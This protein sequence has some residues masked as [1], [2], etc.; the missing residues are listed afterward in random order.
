[1]AF[2]INDI[3][4]TSGNAKLYNSWTSH[5]SKYDTSS[6]YNW[7]Q[8][9]LPLYDI[10]ERTYELWEQAGFPTSSVPGFSL[11]VSADTPVATLNADSTIFTSVS[12]CM[13]A[14]PKIIRFPILIEVAN[15][16][17]LGSL[18]LHNLRIE[19]GGSLEIINRGYAK[20]Y[21]ASST[22]TDTVEPQWNKWTRIVDEVT[23]ADLSGAIFSGI[24]AGACTSAVNIATRVL[25]SVTDTRINAINAFTYPQLSLRKAPLGVSL[26]YTGLFSTTTVNEFRFLPYEQDASFS[27]DATISIADVSATK[28]STGAVLARDAGTTADPMGGS[29]YF[30]TCKKISVKNCDGPI[31]I[32]N[33]CVN[34]ESMAGGGR[35]VGIEITNS[36]VLLEN[37][38]AA[39]CREAGFKFNNSKVVLSRS[40]FSYRNYKLDTASIRSTA[41]G[42]G[43]HAINSDISISALV[44][45]TAA[46]E[47]GAAGEFG[48]SGN[49]VM[50]IA[51]RNSV[52]FK[53]DNSKL[54][55]GFSRMNPVSENT[56]GIISSELNTSCG[57]QLTN[58]EIN[59]EGLIDVYGN[60]QGIEANLSK[61][62]YKNLCVEDHPEEGIVSRNS[63][64][65]LKPMKSPPTEAGETTRKLTDFAKNSQHIVLQKQSSFAFPR[66]AD[67]IPIL[68]GHTS[69]S[70]AHGAVQWSNNAHISLPA[71]SIEDNSNAEFVQ[72]KLVARDAADSFANM[73]TYGLGAKVVK[74]SSVAFYG[75]GSGCSFIWGPPG[76]TL[77]QKVAGLYADDNSEINLHGP[78]VIAQFGVDVLAENNSTITICP[79]RVKD[80]WAYNVSGFNLSSQGNHTSVELHSTRACL[81]ANKNSNINM[82]DL[83]SYISSWPEAGPGGAAIYAAGTDYPISTFGTNDFIGS[84]SLQFY[85]N[86][87][88]ANANAESASVLTTGGSKVVNAIPSFPKFT[89]KIRMNNFL[90][91]DQVISGVPSA[92]RQ[93]ISKGGVCVRAVEDSIVNVTNVHF[94]NGNQGNAL[95]GII[96]TASG[97]TCDRL[98]IWNMADTSRLNAAFCSVSGMYPSDAGYHGPSALWGSA[99]GGTGVPANRHEVI[100][101]GAPVGTPDTGSLSILDSFGAGSAVWVVPSGVTFNQPF[102]RYYPVAKESGIAT[103]DKIYVPAL[104]S[105]AGINVSSTT[106]RMYGASASHNYSNQGVFRIYWSPKSSAKFLQNDASGYDTGTSAIASFSGVVGPAYQ[107]FSQGY[108]MSAPC[109]AM[110]LDTGANVSSIYPGLLKMSVAEDHPTIN[111]QLWTSGFY[112]CDEFVDDNPT[113]CMLDES[114]SDT[115]ANSKNA[116]LGSSGR[117]KKV[118]LYRSRSGSNRGAEA[119]QGD[120][121]Y[122]LGYKS[123]NI[124]DLK[125]DN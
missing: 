43:F 88:N 62:E 82:L 10:E 51:S 47:A 27:V 23:S 11:T 114:A 7:E 49:D 25:S 84:G 112:Y 54:I 99:A 120:F 109:S 102:E 53:L 21:N 76:Y 108:N 101:S 28:Q 96:Y 107:V 113:Q 78:T 26:G 95:D 37:C 4:T 94:P 74:N 93:N 65:I 58:S 125:R 31:Y 69:F 117:P 52:G 70:G 124:F 40:A 77:Q 32:R 116:T 6:F 14:L 17:D 38:S 8:D 50:V 104:L 57:I 111:S 115:F 121:Y 13:A 87:N 97:N 22:C 119:H 89:E 1:M 80:S 73:P 71:I 18:E 110:L 81:V 91:V 90:V 41:P 66:D 98:M 34:G 46:Q 15:F 29:L 19:E 85:P 39:R 105:E 79:P 106:P 63:Q 92:Q 118:T 35:D 16:G 122:S 2:K 20:V 48:A 83:G 86:P 103:I 5:V 68:F 60:R 9:N 30:N 45:G 56:G 36:D 33:F 100:A 44:S 67:N 61:I 75:T 59:L 55:G 24:A 12:A 72:T 64:F 123:S 3:Y 42:V